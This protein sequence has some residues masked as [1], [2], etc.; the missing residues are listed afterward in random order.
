MAAAKASY[1]EGDNFEIIIA[2][3]LATVRVWQRPDLSYQAGAALAQ[4]ISDHVRALAED[5]SVEALLIDQREAPPLIGKTTRAAISEMVATCTA[6]RK[7]IAL[8]SSLG[9]QHAIMRRIV[10]AETLG[11]AFTSVDDAQR[12]LLSA[13]SQLE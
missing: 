7:P 9:V 5:A 10:H 3:R 11:R 12:W 6:K 8:L 13:G 4:R 1:A 2:K